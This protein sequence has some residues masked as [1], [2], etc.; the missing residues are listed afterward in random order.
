MK[1]KSIMV[2]GV[3]QKIGNAIFGELPAARDLL[4]LEKQTAGD[5]MS[6]RNFVLFKIAN[7]TGDDVYVNPDRVRYFSPDGQGTTICF[8]SLQSIR[9]AESASEVHRKMSL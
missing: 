4:D 5:A 6:K 2:N 7:T 8:D 3:F 9:V 1:H